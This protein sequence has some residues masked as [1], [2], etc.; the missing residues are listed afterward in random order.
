MSKISDFRDAFIKAANDAFGEN[1]VFFTPVDGR[2]F[3]AYVHSAELIN[4]PDKVDSHA[5]WTG[6]SFLFSMT[7]G[8]GMVIFSGSQLDDAHFTK[9]RQELPADRYEFVPDT[10]SFVVT[11]PENDAE[12][13]AQTWNASVA[14][15]LKPSQE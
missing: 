8:G 12:L 7:A 15:L 13:L 3:E 6:L 9:I 5:R 10:Q 1:R 11:D 2:R 14:D 4:A